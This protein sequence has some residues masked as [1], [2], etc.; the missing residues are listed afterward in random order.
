MCRRVWRWVGMHKDDRAAV[1]KFLEDRLQSSVSQV[2]AVGV[3]EENKTIE[4]EDVDC[5]RQ[6]LQR[7][8]D[9]RQREASET[10]K[11]VR[12]CINELGCEFVA[13]TRQRSSLQAIA[14]VHSR[15]AHRHNGNVNPSVVH[16]RD[17]RLFGPLKRRQPSD[18]SMR[19]IGLPPEEVR[20]YVVVCI[21]RQLRALWIVGLPIPLMSRVSGWRRDQQS[22]GSTHLSPA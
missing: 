2:H 14:K 7:S 18:G 15:R 19:I 16:E 20:Q 12:S 21:N 4:S 3:C 1:V 17:H 22:Y 10:C 13:A 5:V 11:A 9:I 6:L 8:I